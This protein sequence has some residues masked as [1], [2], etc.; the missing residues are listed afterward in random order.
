ME[1]DWGSSLSSI[2]PVRLEGVLG[3]GFYKLLLHA[4]GEEQSNAAG[5]LPGGLGARDASGVVRRL[6]A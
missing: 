6:C 5:R 4:A 2:G 3:Q 1:G